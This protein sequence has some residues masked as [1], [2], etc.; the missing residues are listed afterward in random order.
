MAIDVLRS[1]ITATNKINDELLNTME[2]SSSFMEHALNSYI[3]VEQIEDHEFKLNEDVINLETF[4][5]DAVRKISKTLRDRHEINVLAN[6]PSSFPSEIIGDEKQL[7]YI[8]NNIV[9]HA[10][11]LTK[12][13]I[14][15]EVVGGYR[16]GNEGQMFEISVCIVGNG[17]RIA[18]FEKELFFSPYGMLFTGEIE[19]DNVEGL[20]LLISKEIIKL[21]GGLMTVFS[22]VEGTA[23]S[24]QIPFNIPLTEEEK[25]RKKEEKKSS[26]L[27]FLG[28]FSGILALLP[29]KSDVS[30]S[31]ANSKSSSSECKNS[32]SGRGLE[33]PLNSL[34]L[35][36]GSLYYQPRS[37]MS[38]CDSLVLDLNTLADENSFC[39][40]RA[41]MNSAA[42]QSSAQLSGAS[43]ADSFDNSFDH[44]DD[45]GL[46]DVEDLEAIEYSLSP[47]HQA[48]STPPPLP[49]DFPPPPAA[50]S[51]PCKQSNEKDL[52]K[53]ESRFDEKV[54]QL[55]QNGEQA[56]KL[57]VLVVDGEI[58]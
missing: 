42:T 10:A 5:G 32:S 35:A 34:R 44:E 11:R 56:S 1:N 17:E 14:K 13:Q 18:D 57:N 53:V 31:A 29:S 15:I 50:S 23:Y 26:N 19:K 40:S 43:V 22:T 48:T 4:F 21:Y 28:I 38:S 54:R 8:L 52:K 27:N 12:D 45:Y 7:N 36:N 46:Y 58:K 20:S 37:N 33:S 49:R 25:A 2:C 16:G 51:S 6:V 47:E 9:M 39:Q 30:G 24:F 3:T 55:E 41:G